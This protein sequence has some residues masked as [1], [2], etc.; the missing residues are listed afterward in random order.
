MSHRNTTRHVAATAIAAVLLVAACGGDDDTAPEASPSS[1]APDVTDTPVAPTTEAPTTEAPATTAPAT[2]APATTVPATTEPAATTPPTTEPCELRC[3]LSNEQ[4]DVVDAFFAAYNGDDWDVFRALFVEDEEF[5][6]ELAPNIIQ[7]EAQARYDFI[8][9]AGLEEVWTPDECV[10]E[11]VGVLHCGVTIEDELHRAL[12]PFGFEPSR[13]NIR[14]ELAGELLRPLRYDAIVS[15]C[16]LDYDGAM[17]RY[18]GWFD[19]QY[20]D[21]D[22]IQGL[23]YRAWNQTDESAPARALEHL[24]EWI[25]SDVQRFVDGGGDVAD[26]NRH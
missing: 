5:T 9:S 25:E 23:H 12:A 11:T 18:G 14:M 4:Q 26:F 3:P 1:T 2:T 13:C 21:Q 24:D 16:H 7:T 15:G 19:E 22:P 10:E 6:W 20:S 17:H 8:W